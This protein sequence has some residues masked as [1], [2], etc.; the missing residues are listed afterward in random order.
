M[1]FS[2][3][4]EEIRKVIPA[5]ELD[6]ILD[7][8]GLPAESFNLAFG[9]SATI[10]TFDGEILVSLKEGQH[11]PTEEYI[12]ELRR[13]LPRGFPEL[14]FYF[15]PAD[16]VSQILNFGLPAPIDVQVA[17]YDPRNYEIAREIRSEIARGPGRGGRPPAPGHQ[18][19]R[20]CVWKWTGRA[21]RS[22]A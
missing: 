11:G 3:V 20:I 7:N 18:R 15:Q 6:L 16:I 13:E 21:P 1:I 4:E 9:D 22:S 14:T 19:S 8:I 12:R 17:G 10:G 5:S 2:R